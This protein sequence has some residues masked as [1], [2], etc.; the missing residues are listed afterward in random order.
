MTLMRSIYFLLVGLV[1]GL[2]GCRSE[3]EQV[4]LSSEPERILN[5]SIK[6]FDK[7]EYLKAQTLME[8]V[9]NQYRGTN[10][11][12]ELFYKYAYTH[13]HLRNYLLANTYFTNFANTFPN[14]QYAQDAEF[15]AAYS[16]Y[17]QSPSYRLDQSKSREAIDEFQDF[18]DKYPESDKVEE[19]NILIDELRK[20]LEE[21][22]FAQGE[23]YYNLG[24]YKASIS[25]FE[26][27]LA[28]FP[29]SKDAEYVRW[30]ILRAAYKY[31]ENSI[32]DKRA[33]RYTDALAKHQEYH[34]RYPKGKYIKDA[35]DLRKNIDSQLQSLKV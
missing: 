33:E 30:L 20:K 22:A 10:Q 35:E 28:E 29:E 3:F 19:C 26:H 16:S 14:S 15:M 25:S 1:L 24:Q 4:R 7:G 5:E 21:K 31:A 9:V 17:K 2:I 23:L 6:Y 12:E 13:Y 11:G 34:H 8:L 27:M 18:A 32:Y